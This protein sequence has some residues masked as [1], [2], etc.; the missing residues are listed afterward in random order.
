MTIKEIRDMTPDELNA[1]LKDL[2]SELMNLRFQNAINQLSNPKRITEVRRSIAKVMT[3][4]R[5]NE[6]KEKAQ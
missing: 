3:V 1:K 4:L 2:K 6:L 5:E